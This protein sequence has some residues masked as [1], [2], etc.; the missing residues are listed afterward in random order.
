MS[1]NVMFYLSLAS[2]RMSFTNYAREALFRYLFTYTSCFNSETKIAIVLHL[3]FALDTCP[4]Y[5]LFRS[6]SKWVFGARF[7]AAIWQTLYASSGYVAVNSSLRRTISGERR[8]RDVRA[9]KNREAARRSVP[10][11]QSAA[12]THI[13]SDIPWAKIRAGWT[14]PAWDKEAAS[15]SQITRGPRLRSIKMATSLLIDY[16]ACESPAKKSSH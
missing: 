13:L 6:A 16:D 12:D 1:K 3:R 14:S 15:R 7:A 10:V 4:K 8:R 9:L 2:P 11:T 5:R